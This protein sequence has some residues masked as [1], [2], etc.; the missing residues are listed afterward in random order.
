MINIFTPSSVIIWSRTR[1]VKMHA[2]TI[3]RY[4]LW[5]EIYLII[6]KISLRVL[7]HWFISIYVALYLD[8]LIC[9]GTYMYF[10]LYIEQTN[11]RTIKCPCKMYICSR[12]CCIAVLVHT[13][14]VR[15][16]KIIINHL[17]GFVGIRNNTVKKNI[18][19]LFKQSI[20]WPPVSLKQNTD[21]V[22]KRTENGNKR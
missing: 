13:I 11:H 8:Y 3:Y 7:I 6:T 16:F 1:Y 14:Q 15:R 21:L 12:F 4:W 19:F 2:C 22:G 17:A 5:L 9:F 20:G 18:E 10:C